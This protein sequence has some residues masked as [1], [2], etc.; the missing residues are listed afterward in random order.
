MKEKAKIVKILNSIKEKN[1][2]RTF[3][4]AVPGYAG[5][6]VANYQSIIG[7]LNLCKNCFSELQNDSTIEIIKTS[8]FHNEIMDMRHNYVA[9]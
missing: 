3:D 9:H 8:L 6:R 2:G 1:D 5:K 7:D 4:F